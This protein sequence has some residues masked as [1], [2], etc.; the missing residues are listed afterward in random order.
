MYLLVACRKVQS[1]HVKTSAFSYFIYDVIVSLQL[2]EHVLSELGPVCLAE[3]DFCV[4]FFHLV[5]PS[6][7]V[8]VYDVQYYKGIYFC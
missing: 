5:L 2:F 7:Q 3:Q 1:K 6:S 4:K 8:A